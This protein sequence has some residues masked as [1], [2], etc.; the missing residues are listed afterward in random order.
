MSKVIE[1]QNISKKYTIYH[2]ARGGYSTLVETLS[3][4]ARFWMK[5][6]RNTLNKKENALKGKTEDFWALKDVNF[7]LNEGDRL[8]IIG[9]NGSGKSTLLKIISRI[10]SPTTGHAR[11]KGRLASLLEVGTG[12]HPELTGRENIFLNGA[13]LGMQRSEIQRNFDEIVEFSE[14]SRFLDTPVKYYSSGMYTRLGFAIAA[15]LDPDILIIDEVLAVGDAQFQQKCLK[16]LNKLSS[17]GRTILFVSHDVGSVLTICNKGLYLENGLVKESGPIEQCVNAYMSKCPIQKLSWQGNEG[18]EHIRFYHCSI[19]TNQADR[20]FFY[21]GEPATVQVE[22]EILKP[23]PDLVFGINIWNQRNQ[24]LARS[25]TYD[26]VAQF[27]KFTQP[28]KHQVSFALDTALFHEGEYLI[29]LDCSLFNRHNILADQITLKYP[30]FAQNKNTRFNH[31][32]ERDGLFLGN[33]WSITS[34]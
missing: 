25:H 9:R 5:Y 2:E 19:K 18:D 30:V 33:K 16:K 23:S 24:L 32:S 28:G 3:T 20:E 27:E 31:L 7:S 26:D 4:K 11:I 1:A 29:K 6:L 10:V 13:I 17:G 8:G 15:H 22:Y 21:Q 12:F 14:L 34:K